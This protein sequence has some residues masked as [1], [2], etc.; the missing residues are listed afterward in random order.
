LGSAVAAAAVA[1][2]PSIVV[3]GCFPTVYL[4]LHMKDLCV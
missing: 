4:L 2:F 1:A 3:L